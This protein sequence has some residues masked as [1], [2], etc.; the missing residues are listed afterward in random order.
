MIKTASTDK[1]TF[2]KIKHF[3]FILVC[4][5][6]LFFVASSLQAEEQVLSFSL[7]EKSVPLDISG[8]KKGKPSESVSKKKVIFGDQFFSVKENSLER[9]YDF[10]SRRIYYLDHQAKTQ[11][12]ISLFADLAFRITELKKRIQIAE[13][14]QRAGEDGIDN[15]YT[16][17]S[18]FGVEG[19][20]PVMVF[21]EEKGANGDVTLFDQGDIVAEVNPGEKRPQVDKHLFGLFLIYDH[22]MH[23]LIRR[24]ILAEDLIPRKFRYFLQSLNSRDEFIVDL[25]TFGLRENRGFQ[26]PSN[27]RNSS[28]RPGALPESKAVD[29]IIISAR[30]KKS[31]VDK[32]DKK[33]FWEQADAAINSKDFLNAAVY[34]LEYGLQS[35]E[36]E[37]VSEALQQVA[38]HQTQDV[39]LDRLLRSL[40][41]DGKEQATRAIEE[42]Q[43]LDRSQV[44]R[45]HV[46]DLM[47]ANQKAVLGQSETAALAMIEALKINPYLTA[48]YKD[49]G[50]LFYGELDMATAW[51]CWDFAR[52]LEPGHFMLQP[53]SDYE[54]ELVNNYPDFF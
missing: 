50:D 14:I 18:L 47:M 36:Q 46:L 4:A 54:K 13:T 1:I 38:V 23:P 10:K 45:S 37:S 8:K 34:Y 24:R 49:L 51:L 31:Q 12:S 33:W 29:Q 26:I 17:E 5:F 32:K 19:D 22:S 11:V 3:R 44:K 52:E 43:K 40:G 53:I 16:L 27:Y 7:T 48:V 39:K 9:I 20:K 35:G 21:R 30:K 41:V 25:Q 28:Q 15:L 42:L 6:F 2:H